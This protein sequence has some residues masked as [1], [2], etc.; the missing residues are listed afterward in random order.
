MSN[1]ILEL[2]NCFLVV[3]SPEQGECQRISGVRVSLHTE[4]WYESV[5]FLSGLPDGT[6]GSVRDFVLANHGELSRMSSVSVEN[7]AHL[8]NTTGTALTRQV[9]SVVLD[10]DSGVAAGSFL[11]SPSVN[12]TTKR[13][14]RHGGVF[15][16]PSLP[17][18]GRSR[19]VRVDAYTDSWCRSLDAAREGPTEAPTAPTS[20][21]TTPTQVMNYT[22]K[23]EYKFMTMPKE[24]TECYFGLELEINTKIPW[25]D[26]HRAMTTVLPIQEDFIFAKQDGSIDGKFNN[27]YEIVSHPMSPRRMR[28]EFTTL[29]KKI[30]RI[31][32]DKG[33]EWSDVFDTDTTSTGI[34]IHVSKGSFTPLSRTHKKKFMMLWNTS[35]PAISKFT[36]KLACRD[37]KSHRYAKHSSSYSGRSLAWMLTEGKNSDR[38]SACN[39]TP[40]TVE[41]RAFRGQPTVASIRHAIDTTEAML[42]FTEQ[43][44]NSQLSRHFPYHF[45]TWLGKQNR[46]SYRNLKRTLAS[47]LTG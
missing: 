12:T 8:V 40:N 7:L 15:S 41:V 20:A 39:E 26:I 17:I 30:E 18:S 33:L 38:H 14:V 43:A 27:S 24:Q 3:N 5:T 42:R 4:F 46:N 37:L 1:D 19:Q 21:A 10:E 9:I 31:V 22:Y 35:S 29:F 47:E 23:P 44:A 16:R 36:S 32:A 11:F 6:W 2:D 28:S 13:H 25:V 34:H 45:M